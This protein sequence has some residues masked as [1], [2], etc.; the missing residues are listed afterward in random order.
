MRNKFEIGDMVQIN[1]GA[2]PFG[3]ILDGPK[4]KSEI[5]PKA[6][7]RNERYDSETGKWI[8]TGPQ[9]NMW[10]VSPGTNVMEYQVFICDLEEVKEFIKWYDVKNSYQWH[11]FSSSN[12]ERY[13]NIITQYA[14]IHP[15]Y[16]SKV[17]E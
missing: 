15:I 8:I 1:Y 16:L 13:E 12:G 9:Q 7:L 3:I 5:Y 10:E 4:K 2:K 6:M 11:I 14:W 17:S